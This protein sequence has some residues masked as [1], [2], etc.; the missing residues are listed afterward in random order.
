MKRITELDLPCLGY[1]FGDLISGYEYD[2]EYENSE[3]IACD[4]CV[5]CYGEYNPKTGKRINLVLRVIQNYRAIKH[6][7]DKCGQK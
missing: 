2:C 5:C 1:Q 4:D 6:Y 3:G 7:K